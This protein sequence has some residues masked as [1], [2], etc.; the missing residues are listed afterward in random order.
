MK[1]AV[2][3]ACVNLGSSTIKH[4]KEEIGSEVGIARIANPSELEYCRL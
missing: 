1:I 4:L 3:A 2:T